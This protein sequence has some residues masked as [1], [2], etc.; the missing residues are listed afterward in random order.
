[1]ALQKIRADA[2]VISE[3]EYHQLEAE[4][5]A[6][7]AQLP[8]LQR[9]RARQENSF[10]V[11]LGRSPRA[12][13][14]GTD[15]GPATALRAASEDAAPVVPGGIP[16]ELLLRRPDLIEA[17]QQLI[18]ANARI[19]VAR[20]AYFPSISLTAFIGGQ[21]VL[22]NR[23]FD[24]EAETH[25]VA[26]MLTQPL[27]GVARANALTNTANAR[28][29]QAL[30]R[31]QNAIR[32]AFRDVRD[33]IAA[34]VRTREQFDV[35]DQRVIALRETLRLAKLRYENGVAS[36]LDVLDAERS[37]LTAELSRSDALRGQRVAI[38][39]LFKALGGGWK[40][41]R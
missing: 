23:L 3:F 37:L 26:G 13:Y 12:M 39:D 20:A 21:S 38:A 1:L 41:D 4:V 28:Q 36:Q 24:E 25:Q 27:F 11:L 14:N 8:V 32:N 9:E 19:G 33:A 7:R 5:L 2:G 15:I 30:I 10:A 6:A 17:E 22:L 31:Y 16:S 40:S 34:Q 35:E 18:A 29:R